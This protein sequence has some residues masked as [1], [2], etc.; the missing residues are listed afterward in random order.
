MATT[1]HLPPP[2]GRGGQSQPQQ[3]Q[4]A[5]RGGGGDDDDD[6]DVEMSTTP[7]TLARTCLRCLEQ[8]EIPPTVQGGVQVVIR[9][10]C[11]AA[12]GKGGHYYCCACTQKVLSPLAPSSAA[13]HHHPLRYHHHP[14]RHHPP[15]ST[16]P[17]CATTVSHR[18]S[19]RL[20]GELPGVRLSKDWQF[21]DITMR[22]PDPCCV[23]P[24]SAKHYKLLGLDAHAQMLRALFLTNANGYH[25]LP[26]DPSGPTWENLCKLLCAPA[27]SPIP[28]ALTA[29][30]AL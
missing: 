15:P 10:F 13:H 29:A 27:N 30:R 24:I 21:G 18:C 25:L 12:K 2:S 14:P 16:A 3:Q 4:P 28:Q 19:Q 9:S 5:T 7:P 17:S 8:I 22:C 1:T 6:D 26:V 23:A 11:D 20:E